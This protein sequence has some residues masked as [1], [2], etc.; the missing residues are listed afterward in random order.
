M[1][2]PRRFLFLIEAIGELD[3]NFVAFHFKGFL[4]LVFCSFGT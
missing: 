2:T 1:E 3:Q 4:W